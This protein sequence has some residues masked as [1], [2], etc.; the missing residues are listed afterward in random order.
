M[1]N[2]WRDYEDVMNDV[3]AQEEPLV[4][5]YT[6]RVIPSND[7][8]FNQTITG[9][10]VNIDSNYIE[11]ES[12]EFHTDNML[13]RSIESDTS[14]QMFNYERYVL[15]FTEKLKSIDYDC[16]FICCVCIKAEAAEELDMHFKS[17]DEIDN[18]ED[19]IK[20]TDFAL[21]SIKNTYE[22]DFRAA[23]NTLAYWIERDL[24]DEDG[25][26]F[27]KEFV[28]QLAVSSKYKMNEGYLDSKNDLKGES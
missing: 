17:D 24:E 7:I 6:A 15:E 23:K 9:N 28:W 5:I 26:I 14:K 4:N 22:V 25:N 3:M 10:L 20:F 13:R 27:Y 12:Q 1:E 18:G 19:G 16:A 8:C 11:T 21:D 2:N